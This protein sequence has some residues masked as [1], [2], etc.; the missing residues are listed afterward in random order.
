MVRLGVLAGL[1]I[2]LRQPL[3]RQIAAP[4]RIIL[5]N[6]ARDVGELEGKT[7]IIRP[8]ERFLI[9]RRHAHHHRHHHAHRARDVVAIAQHVGLGARAPVF[10][11]QLEPG[12]HVLGHLRGEAD[13]GGDHAQRVEGRIAR[14]FA[15][16][17]K[18]GKAADMGEA[19]GKV[20]LVAQFSAH[21]LIVGN[22]VG[23]AA[24]GVEQPSALA[25]GVVEQ[26]RCGGKA[27]RAFLDRQPGVFDQ[28]GAGCCIDRHRP[29]LTAPRPSCGRSGCGADRLPSWRAIRG[30]R[31]PRSGCSDA[32]AG[33]SRPPPSWR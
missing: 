6:V 33:Q 7:Q 14:G 15:L 26:L 16:E 18:R 23:P 19:F 10:G 11:V 3:L 5:D 32:R 31:S 13:F 17:G 29:N 24:P 20:R 8:V 9:V 25:G 12:D 28:R 22:V 21:L 27:L 1:D 4:R 2:L 30:S